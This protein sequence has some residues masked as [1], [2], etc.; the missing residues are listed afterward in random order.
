MIDHLKTHG[1]T[2]ESVRCEKQEKRNDDAL[3]DDTDSELDEYIEHY[4]NGNDNLV[5]GNDLSG[6][7]LLFF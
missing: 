6:N 1:I 7:V 3:S 2:A 4:G 5:D